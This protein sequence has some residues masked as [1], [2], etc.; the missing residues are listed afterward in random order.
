M[1]SIELELYM[2]IR[3]IST[4]NKRWVMLNFSKTFLTDV[5]ESVEKA[6][7]QKGGKS[8]CFAK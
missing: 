3:E 6:F 7:K 2:V 5:F 1:N 4:V 8:L